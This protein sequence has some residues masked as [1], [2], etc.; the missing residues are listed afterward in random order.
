MKIDPDAISYLILFPLHVHFGCILVQF[1]PIIYTYPRNFRAINKDNGHN[2]KCILN[3]L[4]PSH[5]K[6]EK[7][8]EEEEGGYHYKGRSS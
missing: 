7:E 8:K 4:P 5:K 2:F 1:D 6:I 3:L